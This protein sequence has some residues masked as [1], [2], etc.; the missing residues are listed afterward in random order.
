MARL[1]MEPVGKDGKGIDEAMHDITGAV[2][3]NESTL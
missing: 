2:G 3:G 1:Y